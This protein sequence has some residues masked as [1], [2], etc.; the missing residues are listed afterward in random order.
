MFCLGLLIMKQGT[1]QD[2]KENLCKD[3]PMIITRRYADFT[4]LSPLPLA[5]SLSWV[6]CARLRC[7]LASGMTIV[8]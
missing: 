2:V 8:T 6:R 3:G 5:A 4:A 7:G 1:G